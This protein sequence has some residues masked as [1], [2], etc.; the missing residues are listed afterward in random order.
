[1]RKRKPIISDSILYLS[2][3]TLFF[4]IGYFVGEYRGYKLAVQDYAD[5]ITRDNAKEVMPVDP[6]EVY[7]RSVVGLECVFNF[8]ECKD[9]FG[10]SQQMAP[11]LP[12]SKKKSAPFEAQ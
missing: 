3:F 8:A 2:L 1:M 6:R 4:L 12:E 7:F 10:Y 9:R 5:L 11:W